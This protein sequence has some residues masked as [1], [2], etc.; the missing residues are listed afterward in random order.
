MDN[1]TPEQRHK[2]MQAIKNKDSK[3]KC[4]AL[5]G[6]HGICLIAIEWLTSNKKCIN[7]AK[8]PTLNEKNTQ[9]IKIK[10][11]NASNASWTIQVSITESNALLI[12][13]PNIM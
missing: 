5:W 10:W 6:N 11:K 13:P 1:H 9:D 2:N 8:N 4:N 3:T 7:A 12:R